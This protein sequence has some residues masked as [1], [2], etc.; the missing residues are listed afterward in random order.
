MIDYKSTLNLP[1]TKF[2]MKANLNLKE[3]EILNQW[4]LK[5]IYQRIRKNKFGKKLFLL[6]DG[7]PYAN[8]NVHIGHAFNKII[9]DII[10][11][12]K[13]LFGFDASY[14]P[15]WDCH[16]LPIEHQ[17]EK[18]VGK[19]YDKDSFI[20]FVDRC[21]SYVNFQVEQQKFD[22]VRMGIFADWDNSYLTMDFEIESNIIKSLGKLISDDYIF[23]DKKPIYWCI[24]CASSLAE[25]EVE[26]YDKVSNSIYVKFI[27]VDNKLL[28]KQFSVDYL[29]IPIFAI[30]WTT[31][32]WTIPANCAIAVNKNCLYHLIKV[33]NECL[34]LEKNLV[35]KVMSINNVK[36]WRLLGECTGDK[37][38]FIE[39]YH[40]F[41][42]KN[43]YVIL[44]NNID[45]NIGTGIV[46]IAPDHGYDDYVACK[47]YNI[48]LLNLVNSDGTYV[49]GTYPDLNGI[50]VL[51]ADDVVINI[52]YSKNL[53]LHK[54]TIKHKYP[55]CWRH[56]IPIIF[57]ATSQ[58]FI[59]MDANNI[60]KKLLQN[61]SSITWIPKIGKNRMLSM[62]RNRPDWCISR[63]RVWGVPIPLFV[64]KKTWKFH[65]NTL[66]IIERV[67]NYV[68]NHGSQFWWK[69]DLNDLCNSEDIKEYKRISDVLDVWFDSGSTNFSVPSIFNNCIDMCVEGFD[70][71][72][73]WFM[74]SLILSTIIKNKPQ[75]KMIL[76]H[77]FVVDKNY[78]KM[79]KSLGNVI[80]PKDIIN[81]FGA[82]IL[83]LWVSSVDYSKDVRISNE[84]INSV[85]NIY[86]KIRNTI[87]FLLS[88][89]NGFNFLKNEVKFKDMLLIDRL[90]M[91]R[92]KKIQN[93]IINYYE[94]FNF[95][96]VVKCL[97]YFCSIEMGSFYL[98]IIKNRKY[99]AKNN[100]LSCFSCQTAMYHILEGLVRWISPILSFTSD[101]IW[102]FLSLRNFENIFMGEYYSFFEFL[103]CTKN[104]FYNDL[105]KKLLSVK[106]EV[107]K[108]I[109]IYR[110]RKIINNSLEAHII[111]YAEKDL[112]NVF[113]YFDN[114]LHFIFLTSSVKVKNINE[115]NESAH[116]TSIKSLKISL[117]IAEGS[118]CVR[119]WHYTKDVG[120]SKKYKELCGRC[121]SNV[122]GT[123]EIRRFV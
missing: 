110:L 14:I 51:K 28:Y 107:N 68:K 19:A 98:D 71:F 11:K 74:S 46:H 96:S 45:L 58:V 23:I 42:K 25:A 65:P 27:S 18:I 34:I 111:L 100:S 119:C 81:K 99:T 48:D 32:P 26:Y 40:P 93:K 6:H 112:L 29:N 75:C 91:I 97:M 37:L 10:I 15:G 121:I 56:R 66:K 101:E 79:S 24:K 83:R 50:C 12:S 123:G 73:G 16:G 118:K 9:K 47:K 21:K 31:T 88:N 69:C 53:I 94:K 102:N 90:A 86:R 4:K 67:A 70:Q 76:S 63:Q 108:I 13:W 87:R 17:V 1:K 38:E 113:K 120:C 2:S 89:L 103:N 82:D 36:S 64:H 115:F 109:E 95:H 33:N 57:R 92:T 80:S 59:N 114:E 7:P 122:F 77:G 85:V 8:G 3:L 44:S 20:S 22:F 106:Y 55:F 39:F 41:R 117:K 54:N 116:D 62:I 104:I 30:I 43:T 72:R 60:R 105:W 78:K 49:E 35:K 5:K 61:A 52:L 84:I